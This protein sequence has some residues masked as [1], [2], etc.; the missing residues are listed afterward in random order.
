MTDLFKKVSFRATY[1]TVGHLAHYRE[2]IV[3][4]VKVLF[5]QRTN[6]KVD[7]ESDFY[8]KLVVVVVV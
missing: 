5:K 8:M 7:Y 2:K 3:F 1:F 6:F 4:T